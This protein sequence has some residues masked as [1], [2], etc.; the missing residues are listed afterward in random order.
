MVVLQFRENWS[1]CRFGVAK[2]QWKVRAQGSEAWDKDSDWEGDEAEIEKAQTKMI[3][4]API[5]AVGYAIIYSVVA[6]DLSMSWH[7]LL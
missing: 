5:I 4:T 1:P 7:H 3:N 6:V 2:V